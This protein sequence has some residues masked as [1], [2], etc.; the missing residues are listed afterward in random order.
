VTAV[1]ATLGYTFTLG[2]TPISTRIKVLKEVEVEN[3]FRGTIGW[4]QVSFP[5]WVSPAPPPRSR[6]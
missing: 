5:V 2:Q 1:G 4:L 3:R 6:S